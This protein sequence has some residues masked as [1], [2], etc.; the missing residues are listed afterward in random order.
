MARSLRSR[1]TRRLA[2]D[3][4]PESPDEGGQEERSG[5]DVDPSTLPAASPAPA[6]VP[7]AA[8]SFDPWGRRSELRDVDFAD[9]WLGRGREH[10]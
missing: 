4:R 1:L 5:G 2:R 6:H 10:R 7:D 3:V 8:R 9:A